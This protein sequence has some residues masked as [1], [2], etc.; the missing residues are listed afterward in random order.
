MLG[1]LPFTVFRNDVSSTLSHWYILHF[2]VDMKVFKKI[3]FIFNCHK[4]Q[5]DAKAI[6]PW[7]YANRVVLNGSKTKEVTYSRKTSVLH[8]SNQLNYRNMCRV[9]GIR[10][11]GLF[12]ASKL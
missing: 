2:D 3:S 6:L 8:L 7:R 1:P 11:L 5:L 12:F 4:F 9:F 10:D